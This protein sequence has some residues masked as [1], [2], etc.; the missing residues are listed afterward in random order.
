MSAAGVPSTLVK[1]LYIFL[2]LP[3]VSNA[4]FLKNRIHFHQKF[5]QLLQRVCL[6]SVAVEEV[7]NADALRHLFSAAVDPCQPANGHWRKSSCMILTTLAQ[8]CLTALTLQYIHDAGCI[9]DYLERLRQ[10]QLPKTDLTEAF[11]SLFYILSESS[12]TS[13]QL[14]DD[15]HA[16]GG[17]TLISDY[18]LKYELEE[19]E[20]A[21]ACC[22]RLVRLLGDLIYIGPK[23]LR[24]KN[25]AVVEVFQLPG[26]KLS[27]PKAKGEVIRNIRAI[28]TLQLT[29]LQA[30]SAGLCN[31]LLERVRGIHERVP[32][33]YFILDKHHLISSIIEVIATKP[34]SVQE[35]F[36]DVFASL[37]ENLRY[38]PLQ[39]INSV[40]L[41]L[42]SCKYP[43]CLQLTFSCLFRLVLKFPTLKEF[44]RNVGIL[45]ATIQHL[46]KCV[47]TLICLLDRQ[48]VSTEP[49]KDHR[50]SS[51]DIFGDNG[52]SINDAEARLTD[53]L[54]TILRLLAATVSQSNPDVA[55]I[56]NLKGIHCLLTR[57]L[58]AS[59]VPIKVIKH[60][61]ALLYE[62]FVV[63][64]SEDQLLGLLDVLPSA[65]IGLRFEIMC[66]LCNVLRD[67]HRCRTLFRKCNG[68]IRM[69]NQ[70][71]LLNG[72]LS[73]DDKAAGDAQQKPVV[74]PAKKQRLLLLIKGIFAVITVAMKFEPASAKHFASELQ[75]ESL[76]QTLRLLGCFTKETVIFA[77]PTSNQGLQCQASSNDTAVSSN[78]DFLS[79]TPPAIDHTL[80]DKIRVAF[81][82]PGALEEVKLEQFGDIPVAL[83][84][85][86][87]IFRYLIGMAI[88]EFDR[89]YL[90]L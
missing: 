74:D 26:F 40:A 10:M 46:E 19:G 20:E 39:E 8:N 45:E 72:C 53:L 67:S 21:Q 36:F 55:I 78:S 44:Y 6:S 87:L 9:I 77:S 32:G 47:D 18:L 61:L 13:S 51:Y 16:A 7:V 71:V 33:N 28:D 64:P 42:R 56:S 75:F 1:C 84:D 3:C 2:D 90:R 24:P 38:V 11:T 69:I 12:S 83:L 73:P 68:F 48:T 27:I 41:L 58:P 30:R 57:L 25:G 49:P 66:L 82:Q 22:Q 31:A 37:I 60:A 14:L 81:M 85:A 89:S 50:P 88:D 23:E 43:P 70:L 4:D 5:T 15:F 79:E 34:D 29:F 80:L 54:I 52:A 76:E 17:Y 59:S 62:V 86:C 65:D 63:T 35:T